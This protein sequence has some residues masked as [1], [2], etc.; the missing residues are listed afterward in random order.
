[1]LAFPV[2]SYKAGETGV[3]TDTQGD[4]PQSMKDRQNWYY[5]CKM[6]R[7]KRTVY[8]HQREMRCTDRSTQVKACLNTIVECERE[9]IRLRERID[10][11]E[12][13]E[14][15]A[16]FVAH[17]IKKLLDAGKDVESI[18]EVLKELGI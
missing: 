16:D 10:F 5:T 4:L 14:D 13:Y 3:V 12:H 7:D 2:N 18:R 15:Q 6:D 9:I 17:K 8:V 11:L 1:M